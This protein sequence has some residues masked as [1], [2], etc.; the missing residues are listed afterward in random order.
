M[1]CPEPPC[2]HGLGPGTRRFCTLAAPL[3]SP[4]HG[5]IAGL[6]DHRNHAEPGCVRSHRQTRAEHQGKGSE[7]EEKESACD[8][9]GPCR[10]LVTN[11]RA[12]VRPRS[13]SNHWPPCRPLTGQKRLPPGSSAGLPGPWTQAPSCCSEDSSD[14]THF[15]HRV[16][17]P[18]PRR[19]VLHS[20]GTGQFVVRPPLT[21]P[22]T[23]N[24]FEDKF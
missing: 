8:Q 1:R 17:S 22:G 6:T 20:T 11:A 4:G 13:F 3:P 21:K 2:S 15:R 24:S 19:H 12:P 23:E 5:G 7:K 9:E 18:A 10:L 14:R 16:L